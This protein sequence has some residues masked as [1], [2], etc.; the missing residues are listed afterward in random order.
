MDQAKNGPAQSE[1]EMRFTIILALALA[2]MDQDQRYSSKPPARAAKGK[3]A[4]RVKNAM[5]YTN[6]GVFLQK[7]AED[8]AF[9][10]EYTKPATP[11]LGS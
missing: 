1:G 2:V 9:L 4:K 7:A 11:P 5:D 3:E 8:N 6:D 10:F